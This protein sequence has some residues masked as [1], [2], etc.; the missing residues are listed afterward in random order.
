MNQIPH[1]ILNLFNNKDLEESLKQILSLDQEAYNQHLKK[2][3]GSNNQGKIRSIIQ[4]AISESETYKNEINNF[5]YEVIYN[6]ELNYQVVYKLKFFNKLEQNSDDKSKEFSLTKNEIHQIIEEN[7]SEVYETNNNRGYFSDITNLGSELFIVKKTNQGVEILQRIFVSNASTPEKAKSIFVGY[8]IDLEN[9][10]I[11]LKWNENRIKDFYKENSE[12]K[13]VSQLLLYLFSNFKKLTGGFLLTS[14]ARVHSI[15]QK[16]EDETLNIIKI[17]EFEKFLFTLF[18]DDYQEKC[19][20]FKGKVDMH[21]ENTVS[22]TVEDLKLQN[23]HDEQAKTL[24]RHLKYHDVASTLSFPDYDDYI[25]SFAFRDVN[26]TSSKTFSRGHKPIYSSSI[27]WYLIKIALEMKKMTEIGTNLFY[28]EENTQKIFEQEVLL[29]V[30][31]GAL[32][33]KY[34]QYDISQNNKGLN[35]LIYKV[36]SR[37]KNDELFK[38][39]LGGFVSG[40]SISEVAVSS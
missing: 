23:L 2:A 28:K 26:I 15:N 4:S 27:Y 18:E 20:L 24:V 35:N 25:F 32:Y 7:L 37:R 17:N 39:K 30:K 40:K 19:K 21:L 34:Y 5:L 8:K 12:I 1:S 13:K 10:L 33:I 36:E 22:S 14:Q 11:E 16:L 6:Y 38:R 9:N 31:R 3:I 29:Q